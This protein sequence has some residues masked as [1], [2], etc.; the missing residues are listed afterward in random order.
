MNS[1]LINPLWERLSEESA[2]ALRMSEKE[3]A[4][5]RANKVTPRLRPF[6]HR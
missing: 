3:A 5:F 2:E 1:R 4:A 6:A